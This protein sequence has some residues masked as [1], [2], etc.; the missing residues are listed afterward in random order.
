MS[1][2]LRSTV[3]VWFTTHYEYYPRDWELIQKYGNPYH[4][5]WGYYKSGSADI[6]AKQ[7]DAIRRARIDVIVYDV[8]ATYKIEPRDIA[9]DPVLPSFVAA[10]EA[11]PR[12]GRQLQFCINIEN[13]VG[14]LTVEELRTALGYI[15]DTL[16]SS[17]RYY[18]EQGRPFVLVFWD[19][20][21][22]TVLRQIKDEFRDFA[23]NQV[24]W[25]WKGSEGW[26]YV[27]GYPQTIRTDWMPVSP[28]FDSSLEEMYVVD[29]IDNPVGLDQRVHE[30]F[31]DCLKTHG[32][33]HDFEEIRKAPLLKA[34]GGRQDGLYFR[35]Q[36][37]RAVEANP[38][39]IFISG[40]NDWQYQ[41]QIEPAVEYGY[42]YVDI[43]AEVLRSS[44]GA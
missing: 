7:F 11:Q 8:S 16:V 10:L 3:L 4:P 21:D 12:G 39:Y 31:K 33:R 43:A 20:R 35:R 37:T 18:R 22:Q 9:R 28:G 15:R 42:L 6:M 32:S 34:E 30:M 2:R 29:M 5:L 26:L 19:E 1:D 24:P 41:N 40:W 36:L 14:K 27:E 38:R 44:R 23:I 17:R 25:S 13:Y